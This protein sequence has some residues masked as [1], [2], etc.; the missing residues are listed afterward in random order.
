VVPVCSLVGT[1]IC[2]D[3]FRFLFPSL[4]PS[5][6]PSLFGLP[7]G[8]FLA[9]LSSVLA[10]VVFAFRFDECIGE[11]EDCF[12]VQIS[13]RC[14]R[15]GDQSP[16]VPSY[17]EDSSGLSTVIASII[18]S[19]F[20]LSRLRNFLSSFPLCHLARSM[21]HRLRHKI[22]EAEEQKKNDNTRRSA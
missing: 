22:T 4:F 12:F 3:V 18:Y 5:L 14:R 11:L 13:T 9:A 21:S 7:F 19:L 10:A 16:Q 8:I 2:R 17:V 6:L 15:F 20:K 1:D